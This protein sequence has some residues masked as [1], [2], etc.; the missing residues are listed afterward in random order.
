MLCFCPTFFYMSIIN[1]FLLFYIFPNQKDSADRDFRTIP[2]TSRLY[3]LH[4]TI[5]LLQNSQRNM[6]KHK[7]KC[8]Q[9]NSKIIVC[10]F[11]LLYL[12]I[13]PSHT[14]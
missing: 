11:H 9:S 14:G 3:F 6:M 10:S 1:K 5:Q 12:R 13:L 4:I 7:I 8:R 2:A